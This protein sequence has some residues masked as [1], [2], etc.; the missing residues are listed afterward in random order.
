MLC[1]QVQLLEGLAYPGTE[2]ADDDR[3]A[4]W[5]ETRSCR[6]RRTPAQLRN[7]TR[8]RSGNQP[9]GPVTGGQECLSPEA[10][11]L[12]K[13]QVTVQDESTDRSVADGLDRQG[14]LIHG[15]SIGSRGLD[16]TN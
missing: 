2:R 5:R 14:M 12:A 10:V 16:D 1:V 4:A 13:I 7:V 8:A 6:P 15:F 3:A 9:L 11:R